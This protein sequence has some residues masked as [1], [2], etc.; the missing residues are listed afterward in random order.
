MLWCVPIVV[1]YADSQRAKGVVYK[2]TNQTLIDFMQKKFAFISVG[3]DDY[4]FDFEVE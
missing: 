2:S 3:G 1:A 4:A